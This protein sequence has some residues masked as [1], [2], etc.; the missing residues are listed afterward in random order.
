M[1]LVVSG[2]RVLA[3]YEDDV[4]VPMVAFPDARLVPYAGAMEALGRI[5]PA[6][7]GPEDGRLFRAP[8]SPDLPAYAASERYRAEVGGLTFKGHRF[9]TDREVGQPKITRAEL[10]ALSNPAYAI[11]DFKTVTGAFV[12]LSNADIVALGDALDAHVQVCFGVEAAVGRAVAA[13][14]LTTVE[15]V[16]ALFAAIH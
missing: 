10:K 7:T 6:P 15:A 16:D 12:A 4:A 14:T 11:P 2:E 5:G 13:G 9:A 3:Y 8:V 1:Q